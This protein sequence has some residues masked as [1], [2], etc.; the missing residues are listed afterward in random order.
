M[1]IVMW[2]FH[3]VILE[4]PGPVCLWNVQH[5][6]SESWRQSLYLPSKSR[7]EISQP[8]DA[9]TQKTW[10][11]IMKIFLH[12][13]KSFSFVSLPAVGAPRVPHDEGTEKPV[14][15]TSPEFCRFLQK[16]REVWLWLSLNYLYE[17]NKNFVKETLS[18]ANCIP[19]SH[20]HT[21]IYKQQQCVA[22]NFP[23]P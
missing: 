15:Q 11:L 1:E 3:S 23:H 16:R 13:M 18:R 4:E 10:F 17:R 22:A 19:Y 14:F 9:A 2:S 5:S 20:I 12:L 7:E 8:Y 21:H 6:S